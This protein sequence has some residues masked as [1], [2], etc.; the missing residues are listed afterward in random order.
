MN[1]WTRMVVGGTGVAAL[2]VIA[3]V[4]L[5]GCKPTAG[6]TP[7]PD[8]SDRER[9]VYLNV[10]DSTESPT[11]MLTARQDPGPVVTIGP[12][13]AGS[14][15]GAAPIVPPGASLTPRPTRS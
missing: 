3:W 4:L 11:P 7:Q 9:T 6:Q 5:S 10:P 15:G 1:G 12:S 13:A 14:T 8:Q 2:L